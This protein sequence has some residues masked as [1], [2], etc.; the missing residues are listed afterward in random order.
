MEHQ[1]LDLKQLNQSVRKCLAQIAADGSQPN[2]LIEKSL[3]E[4][5]TP[6]K[7]VNSTP[8]NRVGDQF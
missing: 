7:I 5:L 4:C 2:D 8:A 6:E 3:Q 1:T